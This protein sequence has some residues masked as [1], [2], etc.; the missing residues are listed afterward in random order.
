MPLG[1]WILDGEGLQVSMFLNGHGRDAE[2]NTLI[3]VKG[4]RNRTC[5]DV[6]T[7]QLRVTLL[8]LAG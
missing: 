1:V 4:R 2:N 7:K 5:K 6:E 8:D 3:N